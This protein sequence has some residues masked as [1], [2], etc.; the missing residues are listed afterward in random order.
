MKT[1]SVLK[2]KEHARLCEI[3]RTLDYT[4]SNSFPMIFKFMKEDQDQFM[5]LMQTNADEYNEQRI[6]SFNTKL[7]EKIKQKNKKNA[8]KIE[9]LKYNLKAVQE[10]N[11]AMKESK[12]LEEKCLNPYSNI[13]HLYR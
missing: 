8:Q 4:N 1:Q 12:A 13:S 6:D 9:D 2:T 11:W 3:I 7:M 5:R 10:L